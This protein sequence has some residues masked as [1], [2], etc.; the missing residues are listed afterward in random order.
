MIA[1][2]GATGY[3]GESLAYRLASKAGEPLVLFARNPSRLSAETWSRQISIRPIGDFHAAEFDLIVNAIGAGDPERIAAMG[4]DILEITETWDR[5]VLETMREDARYVFFS[6]GAVYG[7]FAAPASEVSQLSLPVNRLGS[8]PPYT[9]AK[10]YAEARHRFN[11]AMAILDV[12]IFAYADERIR[13]DG[14]FF[15]AELARSVATGNVFE[16]SSDD[17]IRDY[18]GAEEL[19]MLIE[20]W[21][22]AGAPNAVMDLYSKQPISKLDLLD[23]IKRRYATKIRYRTSDRPNPT[24]TK[25]NYFS[26]NRAAEAVGYKPMRTSLEIVTEALDALRNTHKIADDAN[27]D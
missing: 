23:H 8:V 10:L 19:A 22:A 15:L 27:I 24:G 6:S 7:S 9:M 25:T 5:R 14:K 21:R 4:A 12:R 16:T 13:R 26:N 11:P 3:V 18:A 1:L 17:M 20:C 2:L